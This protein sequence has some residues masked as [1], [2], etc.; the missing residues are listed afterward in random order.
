VTT[1]AMRL[2]LDGFGCPMAHCNR[3][4]DSLHDLPPLRTVQ[5]SQKILDPVVS[6]RAFV[7]LGAFTG[8]KA[9]VCTYDSVLH[10]ALVAYDYK[11]GAVAWTSPPEDLPGLFQR[12]PSG[13]LLA[14]VTGANG[15]PQHRVFAANPVEFVAYSG[16]GRRLWKRATRD[17]TADAPAGVG[18]PT[19][20]SFT[21]DHELV[22]ATTAGWVVKL[23]P[24]DGSV[25]ASYRMDATVL[26]EGREHRGVFTTT[27]SPVVIGNVLYLLAEFRANASYPPLHPFF[28]PV[29]LVRIEL[30]QP[31]VRG[32]ERAIRPLASLSGAG[33][34]APDRVRLGV[35]KG[36]GSPPAL[37]RPGQPTLLFGH[38]HSLT[39]R[40]LEPTITAVEDRH[41]VLSVRWRSVLR[42]PPGDDVFAAP[43]LHGDSGTLLVTTLRSVFVFRDVASLEGEVPHPEP[44]N[45][46]DLFA[47]A[48]DARAASVRVGSPFGLVFDAD[49][50]EIVAYTNFRVSVEPTK[51]TYGFL[52]A[53]ALPVRADRK[54]HPLWHQPLGVT[55][56]GAQIPGFG[57]FG[58]PALFRYEAAGDEGTGVIVNTVA[59]GTYIFR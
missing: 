27:K 36:T 3:N 29:H 51:L 4:D 26:V 16:D 11:S 54:M 24:V 46:C 23:D 59:T 15:V 40:G 50:D 22:C 49:A 25:I 58:Q 47:G 42:V 1:T 5:A 10:P 38:A 34:E 6:P 52:G 13:I 37:V 20:L 45:P 31:G 43:A 53:F 57:T 48:S 41:G 35:Y 56:E 33:G 19:S 39:A 44:A 14:K 28:S 12:W 9:A 2:E 8:E 7:H 17:V 18:M 55:R 30:S 32:S 21:D